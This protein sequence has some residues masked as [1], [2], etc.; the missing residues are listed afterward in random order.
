MV[1]VSALKVHWGQSGEGRYKY[2]T[3]LTTNDILFYLEYKNNQFFIFC[4]KV[5]KQ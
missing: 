2:Q 3:D 4:N 5:Y 1:N